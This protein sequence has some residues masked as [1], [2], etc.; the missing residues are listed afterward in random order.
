MSISNID[1]LTTAEKQERIKKL[2]AIIQQKIIESK[3]TGSPENRANQP[4]PAQEAKSVEREKDDAKDLPC[5]AAFM[6]S[7]RFCQSVFKDQQLTQPRYDQELEVP[8]DPFHA[9]DK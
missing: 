6:S 9:N 1:L 8:F 2:R 4:V 3:R 5:F 7:V